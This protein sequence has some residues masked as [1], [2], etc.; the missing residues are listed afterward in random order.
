MSLEK[1][2]LL[3]SVMSTYYCS[4]EPFLVNN[5]NL[6]SNSKAEFKLSSG[7]S[8]RDVNLLPQ[9]RF[10]ATQVYRTWLK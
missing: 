9:G 10:G 1:L 3:T 5:S 7:A 2:M 6:K 4:N 8:D